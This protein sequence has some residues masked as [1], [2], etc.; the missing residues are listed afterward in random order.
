MNQRNSTIKKKQNEYENASR[1]IVYLL[2]CAL[3][4]M[5]LKDFPVNCTWDKIWELVEWNH[6]EAL[7]GNYIGGYSEV[8]PDEIRKVGER[9]YHETLYRQLCF[10][11]EREKIIKKLEEQKLAYLMLKGINISKYYPEVGT[12]WMSDNDIL[13]GFVKQDESGRYRTKGETR[14]EIQY[15]ENKTRD[16]IQRAMENNGFSL[17]QRGAC[18][19]E[20]IKPPMF[21]FEM[22][23]KLFEN[24]FDEVK[25]RY[26]QNPW[27]YA[28]QDEQN[29]YLYY[30][31]KEDEYIYFITHAYKHFSAS[32]S[33]IRT[34]VD[35]YVY[36]KNNISMDWDYISSQMKILELEE[37]ETLLRNTA[38]HAFSMKE[39]MTEEEWNIVFYMVGSGTFGTSQNRVRHCL[40]KLESDEENSKNKIW[41]YMKNRLWLSENVMKEN[42]PFFYR[43]RFFRLFM[44][45][46]RIVKGLLIHP[47]KIWAEWRVLFNTVIKCE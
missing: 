47:K 8:I 2:K 14:E 27:K 4:Q 44:P 46:Y 15:W 33:G 25:K 24:S 26:Y 13:C 22:H 21:K 19:D 23:H 17:K 29:S 18:D 41:R 1:Y 28:L 7:I 10:D 37:F 45:L 42:Y 43:Y 20:Y 11:V 32:G 12:R 38:L 5:E 30:Y 16:A 39:K 40:E 31:S 6:I 3:N 36:I 34:L 9:V 35:V